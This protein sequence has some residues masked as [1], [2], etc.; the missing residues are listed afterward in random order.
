MSRALETTPA[1]LLP[2]RLATKLLQARGHPSLS[3]TAVLPHPRRTPDSCSPLRT[4]LFRFPLAPPPL[5]TPPRES[6]TVLRAPAAS[7]GW[8]LSCGEHPLGSEALRAQTKSYFSLCPL[9]SPSRGPGSAVAGPGTVT[10]CAA[11]AWHVL[12]PRV[13]I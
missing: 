4:P 13:V 12:G 8:H 9:L 3:P 6:V 10:V 11:A 1:P 7:V 2:P 5:P